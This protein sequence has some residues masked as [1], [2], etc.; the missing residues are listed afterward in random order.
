MGV[1]AFLASTAILG[2][3]SQ[4]LVRRLCPHCREAFTPTE[5]MRAE[6]PMPEDALLYQ[7]GGCD[8]CNNIG[9]RGRMG[10]FEIMPVD[11]RIQYLVLNR[12]PAGEIETSARDKG[13]RTMAEDGLQ[14]CL[15][16]LTTL[17]EVMRVVG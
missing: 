10:L 14:K 3:M 1:E 13:F 7:N 4:R 16:G 12:S 6:F 15:D 11:D 5:A 17:K 8:A 9:F 2:A